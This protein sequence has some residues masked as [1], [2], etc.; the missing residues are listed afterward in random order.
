[1][2]RKHASF[3]QPSTLFSNEQRYFSVSWILSCLIIRLLI[4]LLF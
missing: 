3:E 2:L 4:L 1:L